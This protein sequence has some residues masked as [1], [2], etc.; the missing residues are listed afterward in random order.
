MRAS[1]SA[2]CCWRD[3]DLWDER[4]VLWLCFRHLLGGDHPLLGNRCRH[5]PYWRCC[6]LRRRPTW[7]RTRRRLPRWRLLRRQQLS[8]RSWLLRQS[9]G[10]HGRRWFFHTLITARRR[11]RGSNTR[12]ATELLLWRLTLRRSHFWLRRRWAR[13]QWHCGRRRDHFRNWWR[14]ARLPLQWLCGRRRG[15]FRNWWRRRHRA[16]R[17]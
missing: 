3:G 12:T 10:W 16:R 5:K 6:W 11:A 2:R 9:Q 14:W 13:P 15:H 17:R 4:R 7:R 8:P 1:G